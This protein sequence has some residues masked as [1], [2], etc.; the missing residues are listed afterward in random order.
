M[1]L[2]RPSNLAP[3]DLALLLEPLLAAAPDVQTYSVAGPGFINV[4]LRTSVWPKVIQSVLSL[5]QNYGHSKLGAGRKV[6]VE[7]VSA[8][9]TG[10]LHV[11]HCRGAVFGDALA[12]LLKVTGHDVTTEYYILV[13]FADY[14]FAEIFD[15]FSYIWENKYDIRTKVIVSDVTIFHKDGDRFFEHVE[16]HRQKMY[17]TSRIKSLVKKAGFE[18]LGAFDGF[19]LG[20]PG[21]KVE[22]VHFVCRGK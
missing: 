6:N 9:P 20:A 19:T 3:R 4:T 12:A 8:N 22:R 21:P 13:N 1:V 14:T 10:P 17:P 2:A 5:G 18:I 7:F 15:D 16:T 11:G